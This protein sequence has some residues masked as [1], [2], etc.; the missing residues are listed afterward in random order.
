[1]S[2]KKVAIYKVPHRFLFGLLNCKI[3]E[4]M[5]N[6]I[7]FSL[8]GFIA[9]AN[10]CR[11][12]SATSFT[13]IERSKYTLIN[14]DGNITID[15]GDIKFAKYRNDAT[16]KIDNNEIKI[17]ENEFRSYN[18]L[19]KSKFHIYTKKWYYFTTCYNLFN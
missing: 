5:Y 17:T 7:V 14:N 8:A 2:V 12:K 6:K 10:A 18:E 4:V 11:C 9:N 1:M 3:N 16:V 15:L 19:I 13:I